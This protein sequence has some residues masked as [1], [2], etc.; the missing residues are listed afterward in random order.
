[1]KYLGTIKVS[2]IVWK[3]F[4][5]YILMT[6]LAKRG[7]KQAVI[8]LKLPPTCQ[9]PPIAAYRASNCHNCLT[10]PITPGQGC[11]I[12]LISFFLFSYIKGRDSKWKPIESIM[13][14]PQFWDVFSTTKLFTFKISLII[15]STSLIMHETIWKKGG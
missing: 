15:L 13:N 14:Q 3:W 8:P 10:G 11:E 5:T 6:Q 12:F 7:D 2:T 4:P 9:K 1:M